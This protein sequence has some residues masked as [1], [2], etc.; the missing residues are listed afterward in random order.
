VIAVATFAAQ[1]NILSFF[2]GE[3]FMSQPR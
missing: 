3:A 2:T 1:P